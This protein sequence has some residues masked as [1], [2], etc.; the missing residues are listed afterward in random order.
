MNKKDEIYK[1]VKKVLIKISIVIG[2][3]ILIL[4]F[5]AVPI[6]IFFL[7]KNGVEKGAEDSW[8]IGVGF[9]GALL[10]GLGTIIAFLVTSYQTNKIQRENSSMIEKQ[11]N[12][13]K[14]ISVKPYLKFN[15]FFEATPATLDKNRWDTNDLLEF[16]NEYI[17]MTSIHSFLLTDS[18]LF[19]EIKNLGFGPAIDINVVKISIDKKIY[20]RSYCSRCNNHFE[21]IDRNN[22][23]VLC[24]NLRCLEKFWESKDFNNKIGA[25]KVLIE[26]Y[27]IPDTEIIMD[28]EYI[29]IFDNK[30]LKRIC[31]IIGAIP[32]TILYMSYPDDTDNEYILSGLQC[33]INMIREKC[34]EICVEKEKIYK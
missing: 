10:G 4:L 18:K 33:K 30:Y 34:K 28:I 27:S 29:D 11:F 5:L 25:K 6:I 14:R 3:S 21:V 20:D 22:L 23:K 2:I 16:N 15:I 12:E 31:I 13:D 24:L 26:R 19:I 32:S 1:K 17:N 7:L 9:Y 8:A